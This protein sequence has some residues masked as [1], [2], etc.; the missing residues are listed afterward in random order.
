MM[1]TGMPQSAETHVL[2]LEGSWTIHRAH[3]LKEFLMDALKGKDH[4]IVDLEGV[5]EVDLSFLQL[6]CSAHRSF[7]R[8]KRQFALHDNKP[9]AVKEVVKD[10]GYLRTLG[11]RSDQCRS[12]LWIG[13]WTV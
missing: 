4:V 11:C 10:A 6:L 12:C 9:E 5:S 7:L 2:K 8:R 3:E 1:N 13:G